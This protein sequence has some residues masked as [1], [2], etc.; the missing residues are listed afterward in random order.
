MVLYI[1][2]K[3]ENNRKELL[4]IMEQRFNY[5]RLLQE[6]ILKEDSINV[7]TLKEIID[8][9]EHRKNEWI[10]DTHLKVGCFVV[11]IHYVEALDGD[12]YKKLRTAKVTSVDRTRELV[13]VETIL[14]T[15]KTLRYDDLLYIKDEDS[16][17]GY[18]RDITAYLKRQRTKKGTLLLDERFR[19]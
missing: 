2:N 14:G 12:V 1:H 18:P 3:K 10:Y 19:K 8:K 17:Y 4:I 15:K 5:E 11:F 13:S 6:N 7:P 16:K 9:Y